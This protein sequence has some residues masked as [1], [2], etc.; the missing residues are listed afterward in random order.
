MGMGA[1]CS[2]KVLPNVAEKAKKIQLYFP[3]LW[4]TINTAEIIFIKHC[5][6]T[7][8]LYKCATQQK[9]PA[10]SKARLKRLYTFPNGISIVNVLPLPRVLSTLTRPLCTS[11]IVFT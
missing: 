3:A 5:S 7:I 9:S 10:Y 6:C 4:D 11:T 2:C 8:Q 1:Y